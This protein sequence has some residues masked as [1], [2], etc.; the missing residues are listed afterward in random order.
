MNPM[1]AL[2]DRLKAR[3]TNQIRGLRFDVDAGTGVSFPV[4][5]LVNL[6]S[7]LEYHFPLVDHTRESLNAMVTVG[8]NVQSGQRIAEGVVSS[9]NGIV[10]GI[11]EWPYAHPSNRHVP[12][13][14]IQA[15]TDTESLS[16]DSTMPQ[17]HT[18]AK[19]TIEK[20]QL[21]GV[22]GLGGAGFSTARKLSASKKHD[23]HTLIINA[24]ECDPAIRCDEA[25]ITIRPEQ[26]LEGISQIA[27][28]CQCDSCIIAIE[29]NKHEAR[30]SLQ[31][32]K[33]SR[34][35]L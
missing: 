20:L 4:L 1:F 31:E 13:I 32:I 18:P 33:R 26:V 12:T 17:D 34:H 11:D 19:L 21:C 15:A 16:I 24:A 14:T 6:P 28:L 8:D 2:L 3:R 10:T 22:S 27:E 9:I 29:D 7:S 30:V 23:I 5:P 35:A 25:L